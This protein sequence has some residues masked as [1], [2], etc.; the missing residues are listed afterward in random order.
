MS[1]RRGS[2]GGSE[3]RVVSWNI[4]FRGP[5]TA[6]LQGALLR[7]LAPDLMLLQEVNPRSSESLR[8]AAGA[9]WM[10]RAID[11]RTA[12]PDDTSVR[13][14][15]VAIAGR[16]LPLCR[17]WLLDEIQ[18]PE[19]I[20]I[21]ETQTRE[22]TPF[23]AVSY[24]APLVK[25]RQAVTFASWLSSQNG[26]LLFG[27]DANTPLIDAF[28]FANTRTHWHTGSRKLRGEPGDDLLFGHDKKHALKDALRCW[29]ELRPDEMDRLR[30]VPS[31][32]LAITHRTGEAQ[33]F[34]GHGPT[35]RF[36]LA[37]PPLGRAA[38]RT[39]LRRGHKGRQRPCAG[40]RGHRSDRRTLSRSRHRNSAQ[41][42]G[43]RAHS[44]G[45]QQRHGESSKRAFAQS[46]RAKRQDGMWLIQKLSRG[47][48]A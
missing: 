37:Q 16:A 11:L 8:R 38:Y 18:L 35:L 3:V 19:R 46:G 45:A 10:V 48:P 22:G 39:P 30:A 42:N 27:A 23:I 29:L 15:G 5:E 7:E 34:A 2:Y 1:K 41:I 4:H 32:P 20:L 25:P 47:S 14:R 43:P 36:C 12:K 40:G 24:H 31:G 17:S 44:D 21:I 13:R 33:K 28:D 9:D 6:N 26:P